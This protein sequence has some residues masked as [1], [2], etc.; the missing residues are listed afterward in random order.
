[1]SD[2]AEV[3]ALALRLVDANEA[4]RDATLNEI[5]RLAYAGNGAAL[6]LSAALLYGF[7]LDRRLPRSEFEGNMAE[8]LQV[9]VATGS[10]AD[11]FYIRPGTDALAALHVHAEYVALLDLLADLDEN[12]GAALNGLADILSPATLALAR[13]F[14]TQPKAAPTHAAP[15]PL[16]YTN[17]IPAEWL[18]PPTRM[19]R[20]RWWFEDRWWS[21]RFKW[22]DFRGPAR[23]S[24]FYRGILKWVC[25]GLQGRRPGCSFR[26]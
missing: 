16:T 14:R 20:V 1:M 13:R 19:E 26:R 21:L 3:D 9:A 12:V 11:L 17:A 23:R 24:L 25:S 15:P 10:L 2:N 7:W 4:E 5:E 6:R 18:A 8:L 22:W